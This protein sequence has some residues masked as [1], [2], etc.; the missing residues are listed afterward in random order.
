MM[1]VV[2]AI[3][4]K[5][6]WKRFTSKY[7]THQFLNFYNIMHIA[8]KHSH[9][10]G[11]IF[12]KYI[13]KYSIFTNSLDKLVSVLSETWKFLW[14]FNR[15]ETLSMI[16]IEI[17]TVAFSIP[18]YW[19]NFKKFTNINSSFTNFRNNFGSTKIA[20]MKFDKHHLQ[21]I[22]SSSIDFTLIR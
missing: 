17:Y 8:K 18:F 21:F 11:I 14:I 4:F 10:L 15:F 6:S 12:E 20:A 1:A 7:S 5:G 2:I 19:V 22:W 16:D 3:N 9:F 13:Y